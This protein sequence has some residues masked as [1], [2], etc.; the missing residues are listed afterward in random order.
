MEVP[1]VHESRMALV[2]LPTCSKNRTLFLQS[3]LFF[4][5]ILQIRFPQQKDNLGV[6]LCNGIIRTSHL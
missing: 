3:V 5:I 4:Y 6:T 2:G 1:R